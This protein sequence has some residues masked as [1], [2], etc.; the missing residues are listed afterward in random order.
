MQF[1]ARTRIAKTNM[2]SIER[3]FYLLNTRTICAIFLSYWTQCIDGFSLLLQRYVRK[4]VD[5]KNPAILSFF[6]VIERT[7]WN[8]T[9]AKLVENL[10]PIAFAETRFITI[11][12]LEFQEIWQKN[13]LETMWMIFRKKSE[14]RQR[15]FLTIQNMQW[16]WFTANIT[17]IAYV[18]ICFRTVFTE[19]I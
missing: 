12:S 6:F 8:A 2:P 19:G 10:R 15:E 13:S 16:E 17:K 9:H 14:F 18:K 3:S 1:G 4:G 11:Q 5:A 7:Q